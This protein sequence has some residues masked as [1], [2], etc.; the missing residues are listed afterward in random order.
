RHRQPAQNAA[1]HQR[2]AELFEIKGLP[3]GP[4]GNLVEPM[5]RD[6]IQAEELAKKSHEI[7]TMN[8]LKHAERERYNVRNLGRH[9]LSPGRSDRVGA[10]KR[11]RARVPLGKK[12]AGKLIGEVKVLDG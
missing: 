8:S 9:G 2:S 12:G 3:S 6:G 11:L 5:L 7:G 10:M 1:V 4:L